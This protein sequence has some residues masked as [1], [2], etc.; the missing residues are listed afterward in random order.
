MYHCITIG[1]IKLDT[2]VVLHDASLQ[3]I[4]KMPECYLCIEYGKKI[5][6]E[7]I[8]SQIAG[9]SANVAVGLSRL[10]FKTAV[11]SVMGK[12]QT[13]E[14]ALERL[15]KEKVE[16][17]Y[18]KTKPKEQSSFSV[19]INYKGEK[20]ILAS[21]KAHEYR[22]PK[23]PKSAWF[24]V[25]ELGS[26]YLSLFK[27]LLATLPAN[28]THL[29]I[30]P[31]A[32]QI[33]EQKSVLYNLIKKSS[34]L[35][36]NVGE[37]RSLAKLQGSAKIPQIMAAAWRLNRKTVVITDGRNGAYGFE[38]KQIFFV[39]TFPGKRVEATG[40]GDS[41]ASGVLGA[42]LHNLPLPEALKWGAVNAASVISQV[43]PQA[44]LLSAREIKRRLKTH[45]S[46]KTKTM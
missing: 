5:P 17:K 7:A 23:L 19:V 27:S 9:S 39:P 33:Q 1:D 16:S 6:V 10:R 18:I 37:A 34:L 35:F 36:L 12:D 40:A 42:A 41:F 11:V 43:G 8:D 44:G 4:L 13:Y 46:F 14:L 22:L 28:S 20:T 38:G 2:F 3:C 26:G 32:I 24:Y 29:A 30:N 45:P 31:G 25:C 15:A 21:H